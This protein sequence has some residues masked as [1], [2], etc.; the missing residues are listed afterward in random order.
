LGAD[1]S[2]EAK[3][4]FQNVIQMRDKLSYVLKRQ[5]NLV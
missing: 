4:V 2:S 1:F 5:N 3:K